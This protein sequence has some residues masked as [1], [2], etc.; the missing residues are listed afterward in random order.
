MD[1]NRPLIT[2]GITCFNAQET[3]SR[4]VE[5]ALAQSWENTE[6]IIVDDFSS[7]KS[8]AIIHDYAHQ[9][10][11]VKY[12]VNDSNLG[13]AASRNKILHEANGEFVVFFDDDDLSHPDRLIHQYRTIRLSESIYQTNHILCYAS[14]KRIYPNGYT[15]CMQA[16]GTSQNGPLYGR[17]VANYLLFND[18]KSGNFYGFGTPTCCLMFR[19]IL[20]HRYGG[21][22]ETLPRQED[23]DFAIRHALNGAYFVGSE[24]QSLIQYSTN[25]LDKTPEKEFIS[26]CAILQK[27]KAYLTSLGLYKY[28]S[29]WAR[30]RLCHF[31]KKRPLALILLIFIF[32]L[33]PRR[34]FVHFMRSGPR[35]FL[36]E[37]LMNHSGPF[38]FM[39][40][41][42]AIFIPYSDKSIKKQK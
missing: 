10:S 1:T 42:A 41:F 5:S 32:L 23:T 35:R 21:F 20:F 22:D 27:N 7:D 13:C 8:P 31:T 25:G 6:I 18:R 9:Y 34:T 3:I 30:I 2:I 14:M 39:W 24:S 37:R 26:T 38:H 19:T 12:Y 11:I 29:L 28:A 16:L 36:H 40:E 15:L 4:A 17:D 33:N